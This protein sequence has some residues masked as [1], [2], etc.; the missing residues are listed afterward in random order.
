MPIKVNLFEHQQLNGVALFDT[1]SAWRVV[2]LG[3]GRV[4]TALPGWRIAQ[5]EKSGKVAFAS[6]ALFSNKQSAEK[7]I[8]SL[9]RGKKR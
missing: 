3:R 5:L 8:S 7:F 2:R 6:A 1:Q 9:K 4:L